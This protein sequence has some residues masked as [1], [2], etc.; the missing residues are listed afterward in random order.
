MQE[1]FMNTALKEAQKAYDKLEVPVGVV[2]VKDDKISTGNYCVGGITGYNKG[3]VN[4]CEV[5]DTQNLI[6]GNWSGGIIGQNE[7]SI[8]N[9]VYYG[10]LSQVGK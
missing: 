2:I 5:Y 6:N 4:N 9:N 7:G 3:I 8:M 10:N 1:K